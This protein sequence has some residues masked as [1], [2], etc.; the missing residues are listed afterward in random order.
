MDWRRVEEEE[1]EEEASTGGWGSSDLPTSPSSWGKVEW[2]RKSCVVERERE[3]NRC[4][5]QGSS[6]ARGGWATKLF[7]KLHIYPYIY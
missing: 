5:G 3:S 6:F 4:S 2:A 7:T 1:E